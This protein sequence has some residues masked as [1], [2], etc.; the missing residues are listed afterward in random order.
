MNNTCQI[1]SVNMMLHGAMGGDA[2]ADL[3]VDFIDHT[4]MFVLS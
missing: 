1:L 3:P 4:T 2:K